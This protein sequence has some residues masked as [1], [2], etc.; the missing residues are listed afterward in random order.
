MAAELRKAGLQ[1][2]TLLAVDYFIWAEL[3]VED[4]LTNIYVRKGEKPEG[5]EPTAVS[6][7][8][9]IHNDVRDK[10]RDIG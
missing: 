10:L 4:K 1:D 8:K 6:E 5:G 7:S 3:Q 2:T 9:L